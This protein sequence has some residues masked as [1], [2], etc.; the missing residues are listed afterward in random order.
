ME[1]LSMPAFTFLK[2]SAEPPSITSIRVGIAE[3]SVVPLPN[4]P[5]PLDPHAQIRPSRSNANECALLDEMETNMGPPGAAWAFDGTNNGL[6]IMISASRQIIIFL[7]SKVD[8]LIMFS[9]L[10]NHRQKSPCI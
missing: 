4:W 8:F 6:A 3:E 2:D 9:F 10:Y 1:L 5:E 7:T